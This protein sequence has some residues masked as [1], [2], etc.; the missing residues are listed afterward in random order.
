[1]GVTMPPETSL[2]EDYEQ[3]RGKPL[4]S[5]NHFLWC[6]RSCSMP[7]VQPAEIDLSSEGN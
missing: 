3:E 7:Y 6:S 1:M 5:Y 4:P 2:V